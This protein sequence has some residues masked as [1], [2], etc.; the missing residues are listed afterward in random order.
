M[1]NGKCLQF[2][3]FA[4]GTCWTSLGLPWNSPSQSCTLILRL[5]RTGGAAWGLLPWNEQNLGMGHYVP[6]CSLH[7]WPKII[8]NH[9][10]SSIQLPK[11]GCLPGFSGCVWDV[12]IN[13]DFRPVLLI[14]STESTE[15]ITLNPSWPKLRQL[16]ANPNL[17]GKA[18]AATAPRRSSSCISADGAASA[19][20]HNPTPLIFNTTLKWFQTSVNP[21]LNHGL[22][23]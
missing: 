14:F 12:Q 18:D 1:L 22:G 13:G 8:K 23:V 17:D 16:S 7:L 10:K 21:P 6:W 11:L 20:V 9:Q 19:D 4:F 15:S 3:F 2:V 5:L